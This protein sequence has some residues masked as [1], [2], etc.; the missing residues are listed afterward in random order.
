V[1][2]KLTEHTHY[3]FNEAGLMVFTG[4]YHLER[5]FCCGNGCL[6]CPYD[7]EKVPEPQKTYLKN[8]KVKKIS[9]E[10]PKE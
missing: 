4:T 1:E 3:Y 10:N 9:P 8:E 5:G 6:H 7:F 2:K